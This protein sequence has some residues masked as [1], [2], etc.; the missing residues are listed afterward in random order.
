MESEAF[1]APLVGG[2]PHVTPKY[3]LDR[4]T[5]TELLQFLNEYVT[6]PSDLDL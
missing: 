2:R 6:R 4:T 3:K 1:F 5:N